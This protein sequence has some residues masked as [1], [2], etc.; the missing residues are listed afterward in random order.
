MSPHT[1]AGSNEMTAR[2]RPRPSDTTDSTWPAMRSPTSGDTDAA[3]SSTVCSKAMSR[4][5]TAATRLEQARWYVTRRRMVIAV[6]W[7]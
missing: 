7:S 6:T 1:V 2:E 5:R 4:A 3:G